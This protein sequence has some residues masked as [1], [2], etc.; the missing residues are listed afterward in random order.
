MF[1]IKI[2]FISHIRYIFFVDDATSI[3]MHGVTKDKIIKAG[4]TIV[5]DC[6]LTGGNPLGRISWFKG[7]EPIRSD[8]I[9]ETGGKYA[10]SR[11]EFAASP[12]DNNLP[13]ICKGQVANFPERIASFTLHVVC[14][15][16]YDYFRD[17]VYSVFF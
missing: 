11:V 14:K 13:L 2:K 12:Y 1:V 3:E 4:D 6:I 15:S 9:T 16:I 8:Y 5:A 7:T 17:Y 10:S